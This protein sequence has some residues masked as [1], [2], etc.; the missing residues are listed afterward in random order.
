MNGEDAVF[1]NPLKEIQKHMDI[2]QDSISAWYGRDSKQNRL[3]DES[4]TGDKE[5]R[6]VGRSQ[7]S[8]FNGRSYCDTLSHVLTV[9][10]ASLQVG[11]RS[12]TCDCRL[13]W[14]H[15][16]FVWF[17]ETTSKKGRM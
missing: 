13:R 10:P 9:M 11:L 6:D 15:F 14:E 1:D 5:N 12:F 7:K 3:Y 16:V 2:I 8:G 4:D 17:H